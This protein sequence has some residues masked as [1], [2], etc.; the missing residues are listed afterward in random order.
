MGSDAD[1]CL[2]LACVTLPFDVAFWLLADFYLGRP[3]L[4]PW[5]TRATCR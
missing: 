1:K 5:G 4:A 2:M 3:E